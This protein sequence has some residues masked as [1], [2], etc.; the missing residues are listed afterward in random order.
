MSIV[1]SVMA[2]KIR[3]QMEYFARK[4]LGETL[5]LITKWKGKAAWIAGGTNVIPDVRA[6]VLKANVLNTISH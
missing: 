6:K 3:I 2:K 4:T 5:T 1:Q